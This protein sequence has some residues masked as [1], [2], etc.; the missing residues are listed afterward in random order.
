[1][2]LALRRQAPAALPRVGGIPPHRL[3]LLVHHLI[4]GIEQ[5]DA[6]AVGIAEVDEQRV[7]RTVAAGTVLDA[8]AEAEAAEHV[9]GEKQ[10]RRFRNREGKMMQPRAGPG[11]EDDVVRIALALEEH[12]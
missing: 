2:P 5:F 7:A 12:E 10:P 9:A 11:G 3:V 8:L 4:M 1:M 6:M